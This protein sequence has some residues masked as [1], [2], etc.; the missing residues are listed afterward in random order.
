MLKRVVF[1]GFLF[2]AG[3]QSTQDTKNPVISKDMEM[4]EAY[5]LAK[6]HGNDTMQKVKE[7]AKERNELPKLAQLSEND[8]VSNHSKL[9][10]NE[11]THATNMYVFAS[12]KADPKV[13]KALLNASEPAVRKVGWRLAAVKP[14]PQVAVVLNDILNYALANGR[15]DEMLDPDMA[16]AIQENGMKGAY[17]FLSRGLQMQG[18]PEYAAAMLALDPKSAPPA[19]LTYLMRA[20]LEDLRQ[21][22]QKSVNVYTCTVIFRFLMENPIPISH[23][24]VPALF[25]FA[26]S[27]NRGLADMANAVLEKQIPE[28]RTSF[29]YML[30]RLP[31]P[32]QVAF[33]ENS[34]REMTA[35]LRLLLHDLKDVAQNKEVIEELNS[36]NESGA[37]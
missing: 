33:I 2:L 13:I 6:M 28:N 25:L 23:P 21:L 11:L 37:Q 18:T 20:D 12:Q 36:P 3:C 4:T 8:L 10:Y 17:T 7:L 26:V 5:G 1:L 14:S 16:R 19:F 32:V 29:A 34:Q 15:E 30:A 31:V 9:N 22:N 35:N 27:R 24:G